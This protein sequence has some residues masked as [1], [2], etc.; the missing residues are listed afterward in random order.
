MFI[1]PQSLI[2]AVRDRRL[3]P[4]IGAG[5]SVGAVHGLA[6]DKQFPD[7]TGLIRRF[8]ARLR[9]EGNTAVADRVDAILPNDAMAAAQLAMDQLG[10]PHFLQ[11]MVSA[12]GRVQSP[13]G[14]DVGAAEAI[15]RLRAPFLITTNYDMALEWPRSSVPIQRIHNDDPTYLATLDDKDPPARR[16]WHLHGSIG[17]VDTLILTTDQYRKLYPEG[18][19]KRTD[20]QNAFDQFERLLANRSFLFVGFSLAEPVLRKKLDDVME[21]TVQT[22]PLKYLLLKAGEADAQKKAHFLQA[23]NVQ[24]IE[25]ENFGLPMIEALNA[26]GRLAWAGVPSAGGLGLTAE[27]ERLTDALLHHAMDLFLPSESVARIYNVSRPDAWSPMPTGGDGITMLREAIQL[28]AGGVAQSSN[29]LPPLLDFVDRVAAEAREPHVTRLQN[30]LADAVEHI[31][32]DAADRAR[33]GQLLAAARATPVRDRAQ[34]LVRIQ[35]NP[36]DA[37]QWLVHAWAYV[38]ARVPEALF[39][40]EGK[41]FKDGSSSELVYHLVEELEQ[42]PIDPERTSIAFIVSST[43]ACELIHDWRLPASVSTDP[44]IGTNYMVTVRSLERQQRDKL[45]R[46][47]FKTAW[48]DFK[49]RAARM[50]AVLEPDA[51]A[52]GDE[53]PALLIDA[54]T[55]RRPDLAAFLQRQG[56]RGVVLREPPCASALDH[57]S[58]VLNTMTPVIVWSEDITAP[59][60]EKEIRDLLQSVP[61]SELPRRIRDERARAFATSLGAA[62]LVAGQSGTS[63]KLTLLWDDAD[64]AP[65]EDD[66]NAK[67]RLETT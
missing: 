44:P 14:A 67:A 2:E 30:W 15:W 54:A 33:L 29:G 27:M 47:R 5:V 34:V 36:A 31:G 8:S 53:V 4:F 35:S 18:S 40:A 62:P 11:E 58:A 46:R 60:V 13:P 66:P 12:F 3:I 23:Y 63:G 1:P 10:R 22:A 6:P 20:Y 48:N 38:G 65:P 50:L 16:I 28:L 49:A 51:P 21:K 43:L 19:Q 45:V 9:R 52:P 32:V 7:W 59:A 37:G 64:Y 39:G 61:I 17:R 56:A 57:L 42:R 25:F 24:V 26:I 55:A 41:T